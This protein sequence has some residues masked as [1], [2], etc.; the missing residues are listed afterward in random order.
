M[1]WMHRMVSGKTL[2][3]WHHPMLLIETTNPNLTS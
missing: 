3:M 2:L 1:H